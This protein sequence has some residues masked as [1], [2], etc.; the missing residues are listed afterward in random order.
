[1][2]HGSLHLEI[3][4]LRPQLL[5]FAHLQLRDAAAAEDAVQETLLAALGGV[6]R[7]AGQAALRTWLIGILRNKIVDHIRRCKR[8]GGRA[9]PEADEGDENDFDVLF[10]GDGHWQEAPADWGDPARSLENRRFHDVFEACLEILPAQ[11][12]R[13][14]LMREMLG[15]ETAEIC[16]ELAISTSNCW[17]VLY[18]AR[19]RLREC[20]QKNWFGIDGPGVALT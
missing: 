10:A 5:R 11:T 19:M 15:L 8:D 2:E 6:D 12:A 16:K 1:M 13:V 14:F 17:V 7:Y 18:R 20:L 3:A 4:A 9:A